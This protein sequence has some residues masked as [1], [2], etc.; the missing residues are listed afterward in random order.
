MDIE[1]QKLL[2]RGTFSP[3]S[4]IYA[5]GKIINDIYGGAAPQLFVLLSLNVHIIFHRRSL[6]T[7]DDHNV[8]FVLL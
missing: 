4:D 5:L 8:L 6:N 7:V 3:R 1:R 2:M